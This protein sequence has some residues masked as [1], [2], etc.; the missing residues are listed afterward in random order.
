[1]CA[2]NDLD[3]DH[4]SVEMLHAAVSAV[5][6]LGADIA[7]VRARTGEVIAVA[8]RDGWESD[9]RSGARV[10]VRRLGRVDFGARVRSELD[11]V[12]LE[13]AVQRINDVIE[14]R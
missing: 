2:T 3:L 13:V 5:V 14:R 8:E 11:V 4:H 6:R 9:L 7:A 12:A 1:M 10:I